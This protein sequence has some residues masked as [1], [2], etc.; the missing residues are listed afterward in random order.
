MIV[1]GC[2]LATTGFITLTI[3]RGGR[4]VHVAI[5]C[6]PVPQYKHRPWVSHLCRSE[7]ER[8]VRSTCMGSWPGFAVLRVTGCRRSEKLK[9]FWDSIKPDC[10]RLAHLIESLA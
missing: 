1:R 10:I 7:D 8:Q 2:I 5:T 3:G 4:I 6:P 9:E